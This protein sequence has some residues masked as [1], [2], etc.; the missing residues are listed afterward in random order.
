MIKPSRQC[1]RFS[2]P[3]FA[4]RRWIDGQLVKIQKASDD[5]LAKLASAK[6]D[7]QDVIAA[8][9]RTQSLITDNLRE[10][11]AAGT[12]ADEIERKHNQQFHSVLDPG[13][14]E[15]L[16]KSFNQPVPDAREL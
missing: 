3:S 7:V 15:E 14:I 6:P 11:P 8:W 1:G 12:G 2:R 13:Q 4:W 16:D 9:T 5:L 10:K